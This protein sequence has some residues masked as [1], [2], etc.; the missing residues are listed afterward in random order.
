MPSHGSTE[1][2]RH[3]T[4]ATTGNES[5]DRIARWTHWGFYALIGGMV[6][7]GLATALGAGLLPIVFGGSGD[8]LP[9]T[10]EGMPQL[11]VHGFFAVL[12]IALIVLHVLAAIYHHFILKDGLIRRMWFGKRV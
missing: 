2:E 7:S 1:L 4:R 11:F 5:L 12:L 8:P 10:F 9:A 6:L 3:P